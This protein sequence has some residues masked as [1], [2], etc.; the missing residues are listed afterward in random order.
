MELLDRMVILFLVFHSGCTNL[1][2]H[3]QCAPSPALVLCRLCNDGYS[4]RCEVVPCCS[5]DL[6]FSNSGVEHLFLCL[7]AI[8]MSSLEKC[9]LRSSAHF[10]DWVV[11][12]LLLLSCKSCSYILEIKPLSVISFAKIF[13]PF[14]RL[15]FHFF[16]VSLAV[17]KLLS[18]FG[19]TE[20]EHLLIPLI[21]Y[22]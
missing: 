10:F 2:S 8:C 6:H 16:M 19:P 17:Q 13:L 22:F 5:F 1:H 15:S 4:D 20:Y 14:C 18:R 3:E 21:L 11:C 7:L 12:F 9:V